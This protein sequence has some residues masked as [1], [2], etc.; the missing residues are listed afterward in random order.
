MKPASE[1]RMMYVVDPYCDQIKLKTE[2]DAL[3]TYGDGKTERWPNRFATEECAAFFVIE[4]ARR[5]LEA[6]RVNLLHEEAHLKRVL[7][8]FGEKASVA[9]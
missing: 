6:A 3:I 9:A 1:K 7:K 2:K 5:K 8:K 4:R